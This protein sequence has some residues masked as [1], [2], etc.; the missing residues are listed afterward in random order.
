MKYIQEQ[1]D[2]EVVFKALD[3]VQK[4][5]R[6]ALNYASDFYAEQLNGRDSHDNPPV[7][8]YDYSKQTVKN[9]L[10]LMHGEDAESVSLFHL[11][12]LMKFLRYE[13]KSGNV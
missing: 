1:G 12:E 5:S 4:C 9:Y 6:L 13:G 2:L 11:L 8:N 10:D 7:F 3:G